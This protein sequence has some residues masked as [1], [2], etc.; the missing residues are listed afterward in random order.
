MI[1]M[2]RLIVCLFYA[3]LLG[4]FAGTAVAADSCDKYLWRTV[5]VT[6]IDVTKTTPMVQELRRE[7]QRV[8]DAGPLGPLRLSYA[9]LPYEAYWIYYERGRI[10]TTLA[11]AYPHL[12]DPQQDA[13]LVHVRGLLADPVHAPWTPGIKGKTDGAARA[14]HGQQV[15]EGRYPNAKDCPTL[16]VLY[17]LWLYGHRTNDWETIRSCW[18]KIKQYYVQSGDAIFLYGQ[19]SAHI[20]VARLARRFGDT[21]AQ[22]VAIQRL[23]KDL[24]DGKSIDHIE[25]RQKKIRFK[26]FYDDRNKSRFK[27]QPW[28]FLDVSPELCRFIEDNL[29]DRAIDKI[30]QIKSVYPLWWLH[31]APYFTRWTGDEGIGVS[32][33]LFGMVYP[34]ERWVKK[35]SPDNLAL[36]MRSMPTGIGDCYWLEGLA[37]TIEAFGTVRWDTLTDSTMIAEDL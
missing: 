16:H 4:V 31:Q 32:P 10:I 6:N 30:E 25:N 19:M 15:T 12:S 14:L 17:G 28:M 18:P 27:G 21:D 23:A 34:I 33:E 37:Q 36:Y 7:V 9:D 11:W 29:K 2:N 13:V 20:A 1:R 35:T 26:A 3:V 24:E 5:H 8:L 22:A